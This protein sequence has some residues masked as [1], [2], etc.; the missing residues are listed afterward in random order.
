MEFSSAVV[1]LTI[2]AI[3]GAGRLLAEHRHWARVA[4]CSSAGLVG[5]F[6]TATRLT[7]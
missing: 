6:W 4:V 5:L 2:G 3:W 7:T 1:L